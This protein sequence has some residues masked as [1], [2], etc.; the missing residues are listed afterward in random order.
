MSIKEALDNSILHWQDNLERVG[1][2]FLP[3]ISGEDCD[4]CKLFARLYSLKSCEGCPV[5]EK[6][7]AIACEKT[8]YTKVRILVKSMQDDEKW[9][10][11]HNKEERGEI[12]DYKWNDLREAVQE[13]LDF[14]KG[15]KDELA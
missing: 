15:L 10:I 8:P 4:L 11:S 13:E 14:L 2:Y 9:K 1:F 12:S 3:R 7:G 6:T 5:Y